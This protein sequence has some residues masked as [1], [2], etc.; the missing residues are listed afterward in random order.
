MRAE[1]H[2]E[3]VALLVDRDDLVLGQLVGPLGF[4]LLA[5]LDEV[6]LDLGAVPHRPLD[7]QIAVDDLAHPLL[8]LGEIL[9]REGL[10]ADEVVIEA[11]L[12]RG[13]ERDLR[14][15]VELLHRLG[16]H[17]R[18]VVAQQLERVRVARCHDADLGV[19][20]DHMGEVDH[21]AVDT[22]CQGSLGEAGTDRGGDL[23]AAHRFVK[24]SD[25]T[26]RQG[27]IDH[28]VH[29]LTKF[30]TQLICRHK[31]STAVGRE[32]AQRCA[33]GRFKFGRW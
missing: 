4:E 19:A 31:R 28:L 7:R 22:K 26:V 24:G 5:V 30:R 25:G 16:Q 13:T 27:N 10:L 20:I 3:P 29:Q 17:V 15:G 32:A 33:P 14:S 18:R 21:L 23:C 9:G 8:D 6:V 1:A 11:V 2:V 12:R